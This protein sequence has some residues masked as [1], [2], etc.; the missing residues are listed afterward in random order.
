MEYLYTLVAIPFIISSIVLYL[1]YKKVNNKYSLTLQE[2]NRTIREGYYEGDMPLEI[3]D[4]DGNII[5]KH[6][7]HYIIYVNEI[8]RYTNG[9]SKVELNRIEITSGYDSGQYEHIRKV[10]TKRFCSVIPSDKIEWLE[11]EETLKQQRK[12]KIETI[13][14]L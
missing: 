11:S 1:K 7:Y 5:S 2:F 8:D 13:E 6:K 10:V 9:E 4:I 14:N 3:S 12:L